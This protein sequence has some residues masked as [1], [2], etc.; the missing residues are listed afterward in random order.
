[1]IRMMYDWIV[2]NGYHPVIIATK[3]DKLKRSQ[4]AKQIKVLRQGLGMEKDDILIP[5]SAETKQGRDE[6]W[7]FIES[8]V[9]QQEEA[10]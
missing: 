2:A 3:L 5:F 8:M 6:I 4:V 7:D 10:E 1:M 9:L